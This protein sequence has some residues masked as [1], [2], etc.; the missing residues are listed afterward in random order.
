MYYGE[1][2]AAVEF[3]DGLGYR[4]PYGI[5]T[6]DFLL[7][8]ASGDVAGGGRWVSLGGWAAVG[9]K[10][11]A[12]TPMRRTWRRQLQQRLQQPG[13]AGPLPSTTPKHSASRPPSVRH[14]D[15]EASRLHLIQ[16]SEA[17]LRR[18]PMEGFTAGKA[19]ELRQVRLLIVYRGEGPF[20]QMAQACHRITM[21]AVAG[22]LLD[23]LGCVCRHAHWSL[24]APPAV[25]LRALLR[26]ERS[27]Q[28]A[29]QAQLAPPTL[30]AQLTGAWAPP[31]PSSSAASLP[32]PAAVHSSNAKSPAALTLDSERPGASSKADVLDIETGAGAG[33]EAGVGPRWGAPY[34]TQVSILLQRSVRTRR[35][36]VGGGGCRAAHAVLCLLLLRECRIVK[37]QQPGS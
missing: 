36:E 15:G 22:R 27:T 30:Q 25:C 8:L 14:R 3:F 20:H 24:P 33:G 5:N 7:D 28:C 1:A 29:Q 26:F 6:A 31:S 37:S 13:A 12:V 23:S 16:G 4:L 19:P 2:A 34:L 9:G 21:H 32:Q 11:A 10:G 18:H 17:F 35:F